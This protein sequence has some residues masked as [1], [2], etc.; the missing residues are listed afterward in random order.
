MII[1]MKAGSTDQQIEAVSDKMKSMGMGA[2]VSRGIER[3]VIG[4]NGDNRQI[5]M[6]ALEVVSVVENV[7]RVMKLYM[8]GSRVSHPEVSVVDIRGVKLGGKQVQII[9]GPCSVETQPQMDSAAASVREAGCN[10]MRGGAIKPR[11]SPS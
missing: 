8:I 7:V 5:D 6:E 3:T 4:A 11:T 9:G 2:H 1:I 10:L